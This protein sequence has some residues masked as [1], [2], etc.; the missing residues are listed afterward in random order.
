MSS[1]A[2]AAGGPAS[3]ARRTRGLGAILALGALATCVGV[4]VGEGSPVVAIS[5][6]LAGVL[7]WGIWKMPVRSTMLG[8]MFL[9][10]AVDN[11]QERPHAGLW[12][13]PLHSLGQLYFTNLH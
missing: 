5:P 3:P 1:A 13:S 9:A 10:L 12:E 8:L 6:L 11:P 7:L 2:G 4:V